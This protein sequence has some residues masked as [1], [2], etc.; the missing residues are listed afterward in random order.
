MATHN[1][2]KIHS[3]SQ[4]AV[5]L[6]LIAN[7][8]TKLS[9]GQ[10]EVSASAGWST[11]PLPQ[12]DDELVA[13]L[14]RP[15][16][17]IW[18]LS[19]AEGAK[20][21]IEK[22]APRGKEVDVAARLKKYKTQ[23]LDV[24]NAIAVLAFEEM[25]RWVTIAEPTIPLGSE[26]NWDFYL[27]QDTFRL[28][29]ASLAI[30]L[31]D[32]FHELAKNGSLPAQMNLK[33]AS[34][35]VA[36]CKSELE[37]LVIRNDGDSGP[38][39]YANKARDNSKKAKELINQL[40]SRLN[41]SSEA[42]K[43]IVE[44]AQQG[45][46]PAMERELI[47]VAS[48][49][50]YTKKIEKQA[51]RLLEARGIDEA[52]VVKVAQTMVEVARATRTKPAKRILEILDDPHARKLGYGQYVRSMYFELHGDKSSQIACLEKGMELGD[53]KCAF[54]YGFVQLEQKSFKSAK[55]ALERAVQ[56]GSK[57]A[58]ANLAMIYF[59]GNGVPRSLL[60]GADVLD[61]GAQLRNG[62][63][64]SSLA[65][66]FLRDQIDYP[67]ED[68]D[69]DIK[70][71]EDSKQ[72]VANLTMARSLFELAI[73]ILH[74]EGDEQNAKALCSE[75]D[76]V[77]LEIIQLSYPTV[78][79]SKAAV[80]FNERYEKWKIRDMQRRDNKRIFGK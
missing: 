3:L 50:G 24:Q 72:R 61:K 29:S 8:I 22:V 69:L 52:G 65:F 74:K 71:D 39:S 30:D 73:D 17:A 38:E 48:E 78:D 40:A 67:L 18:A 42:D 14:S 49:S 79:T 57:E 27:R 68:F 5:V 28:R 15:R 51:L 80:E 21:L 1:V 4:I 7:T 62:F 35:F 66:L 64:A 34:M 6:F 23:S 75:L 59:E 55:A 13:L 60:N 43:R 58:A 36:T 45:Y 56:L 44:L 25:T 70:V 63:C 76:N 77:H 11:L 47:N 37:S 31:S 20:Q 12:S 9:C 53:P 54:L 16:F 33:P 46:W 26:T 2:T 10:E 41:R 19:H 32:K